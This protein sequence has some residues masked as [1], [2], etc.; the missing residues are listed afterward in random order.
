MNKP[1]DSWITTLSA[2][3]LVAHLEVSVCGQLQCKQDDKNK[4]EY[5]ELK[6]EILKRL[7]KGEKDA[8]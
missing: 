3:E 8:V 4:R 1:K 5:F 6:Q 2:D 7:K